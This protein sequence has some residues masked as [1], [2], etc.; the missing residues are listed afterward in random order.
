MAQLVRVEGGEDAAQQTGPAIAGDR[1]PQGMESP[2]A[3]GEGHHRGQIDERHRV[4]D[5]RPEGK[6]EHHGAERKVG[7][8]HGVARGIEDVALEDL[9]RVE[10]MGGEP[11][12]GPQVHQHVEVAEH[13][14]ADE[15]R[16]RPRGRDREGEKEEGGE[17]F[18]AEGVLV[19]HLLVFTWFKS[20]C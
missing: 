9:A 8:Q 11:V 2:P 14:G 13:V 1:V 7:M 19:S 18:A 10:E 17:G 6:Q 20:A 4:V 12:D 5:E 16:Q 15:G 3:E